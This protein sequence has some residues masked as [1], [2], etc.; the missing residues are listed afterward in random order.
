MDIMN[1]LRNLFCEDFKA[2]VNEDGGTS[3][4]V[5]VKSSTEEVSSHD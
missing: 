4:S 1:K 5:E 3:Y 2:E